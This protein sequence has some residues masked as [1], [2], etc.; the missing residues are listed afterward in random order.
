MHDSNRSGVC[1]W[2]S[3]IREIRSARLYREPMK[4][5]FLD[6]GAS[7]CLAVTFYRLIR[8]QPNTCPVHIQT[9]QLM[10]R[11]DVIRGKFVISSGENSHAAF[12]CHWFVEIGK[13]KYL[14][15]N[16]WLSEIQDR[17]ISSN[18]SVSGLSD[19]TE[20]LWNSV[21]VSLRYS[22]YHV[23]HVMK[24]CNKSALQIRLTFRI[25]AEF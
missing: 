3:E 22:T 5:I 19:L 24:Y 23:C 9:G 10:C 11:I 15:Y 16:Q 18:L 4:H 13:L 14:L 21:S 6:K 12:S 17:P 20:I 25:Y 8:C 1:G 2:E 7:K